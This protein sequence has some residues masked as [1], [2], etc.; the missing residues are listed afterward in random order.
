MSHAL[1]R[2]IS[3]HGVGEEAMAVVCRHCRCI[4]GPSLRVRWLLLNVIV[5]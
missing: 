3:S 5:S 1:A 4:F 2:L